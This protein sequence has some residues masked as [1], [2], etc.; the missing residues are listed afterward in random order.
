MYLFSIYTLAS[1]GGK[2]QWATL[3]HCNVIMI[4]KKSHPTLYFHSF[5]VKPS[6]TYRG[7]AEHT[8][9]TCL[10]GGAKPVVFSKREIHFKFVN[11]L[12]ERPIW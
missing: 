4:R 3:P 11:S 10:D 6:P 1:G 7:L 2:V 8:L 12:T 9:I 5:V